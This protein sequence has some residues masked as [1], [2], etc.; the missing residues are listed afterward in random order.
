[1]IKWTATNWKWLGAVGHQHGLEERLIQERQSEVRTLLTA[2][3]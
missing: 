3:R 1:M 2:A